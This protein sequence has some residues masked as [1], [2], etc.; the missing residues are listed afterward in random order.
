[1][2]GYFKMLQAN[3]FREPISNKLVTI[4]W[5]V[6]LGLHVRVRVSLG[7]RVSKLLGSNYN[8]SHNHDCYPNSNPKLTQTLNLT[9]T[10]Y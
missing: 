9:L 1:M 5:F 8:P 3:S 2:R 6:R 4:I 7:V 10:N